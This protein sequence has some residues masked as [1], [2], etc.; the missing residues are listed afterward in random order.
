MAVT[1]SCQGSGIGRKLLEA[2]IEAARSAGARRLYRETNHVLTPAIRLLTGDLTPTTDD[3]TDVI[4]PG[5]V[6]AADTTGVMRL[7]ASD[8]TYIYNLSVNLPKLNTDYT[9]IV[10]P[11]ASGTNLGIA[12]LAH[13][14]QATK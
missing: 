8:G 1:S 14:I 11:Y 3:S 7:S 9:V 6:S 4:T 2:A 12:K 10:Y 5:S 13:V